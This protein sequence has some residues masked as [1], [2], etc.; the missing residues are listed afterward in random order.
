MKYK[1]SPNPEYLFILVSDTNPNGEYPCNTATLNFLHPYVNGKSHGFLSWIDKPIKK[2]YQPSA[3]EQ[4]EFDIAELRKYIEILNPRKVILFGE[5]L[6]IN[7]IDD[8]AITYQKGG[9]K[10]KLDKAHGTFYLQDNRIYIPTYALQQT[11]KVISRGKGSNT[12]DD[13]N[14]L[15][16]VKRDLERCFSL[17]LENIPYPKFEVVN[18]IESFEG[19]QV[20]LDIETTGLSSSDRITSI[21]YK[22]LDTDTVNI[23]I[24]P[25][26]NTVSTLIAELEK[27]SLI[28]G[29]NLSFDLSMLYGKVKKSV[30]IDLSIY[31]T[32]I[33]AYF[34]G[35]RVLS[36]KHLTVMYTDRLGNNAYKQGQGF[37]SLAYVSEDVLTTIELYNLQYDK[38]KSIDFFWKLTNLVL[39]YARVKQDGI[40]ISSQTLKNLYLSMKNRVD[41]EILFDVRNL[42]PKLNVDSTKQLADVLLK[43]GVVLTRKTDKGSYKLDSETLSEL[44]EQYPENKTVSA[45]LEYKQLSSSLNFLISYMLIAYYGTT[46]VKDVNQTIGY[47]L[48]KE[49]NRDQLYLHSDFIL[50]GTD[51]GR[52]SSTNPNLQQISNKTDTNSIFV[53]R[54][55]N[56][57]ILEAD[58]SQAEVR[59]VAYLSGDM[60]F[61]NA[62]NGDVHLEVA[63]I[64]WGDPLL[65]KSTKDGKEKRQ[66]AKGIVFALM[67]GKQPDSVARDLGLDKNLV[68]KAFDMFF[69]SFPDLR[70]WMEKQ[71]SKVNKTNKIVMPFG[72][73][74]YVDSEAQYGKWRV[75]N[76]AVNTPV[77]S[78]ASDFNLLLVWYTVHKIKDMN[79][80]SVFLGSVHDSILFDVPEEESDLIIEIIQ[81][82]Y[83]WL[84]VT[85]LKDFDAHSI[86][87]L[88]GDYSLGY[89]RLDCKRNPIKEGNFSSFEVGK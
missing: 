67:Y 73:V 13:L 22:L 83:R 1:G 44:L 62:C 5:V 70:K 9:Y 7:L 2:P 63:R 65:D 84:G 15:S 42:Y 29:H 45:V 80:K 61:S 55:E 14:I 69:T 81:E 51:T 48:E 27:S 32:M 64:V 87:P 23:L 68:H 71:K 24:N 75:D 60:L 82:A 21:A 18:S 39:V 33:G 54:F 19:R 30:N 79:M 25:T 89:S 4:K 16:Y 17:E 31:D 41:N 56:G 78:I 46:K 40:A 66:I 74:R 34:L 58:L 6:A 26:H 20:C 59:C 3:K 43:E 77:Q 86:L 88:K 47:I 37:D 28:I 12:V 38:V 53:S 52:L 57:Y 49:K 76:L 85:Y 72:R 11:K 36:L 10:E 8:I 35:E 50:V